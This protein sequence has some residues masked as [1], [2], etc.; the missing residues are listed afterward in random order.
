MS[1]FKCPACEAYCLQIARVE[2]GELD[3]VLKDFLNHQLDEP[4]IRMRVQDGWGRAAFPIS[5]VEK[6]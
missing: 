4:C 1:G 5:R 6:E 2:R 3:Q